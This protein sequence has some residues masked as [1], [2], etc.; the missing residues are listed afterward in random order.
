MNWFIKRISR[1]EAAL[2]RCTED[3]TLEYESGKQKVLDPFSA[4]I[5]ILDD[6]HNGDKPVRVLSNN[7]ASNL[8]ERL[9]EG[10]SGEELYNAIPELKKLEDDPEADPIS[11]SIY[12]TFAAGKAGFNPC[13]TE[14]EPPAYLV[15]SSDDE[16]EDE[17]PEVIAPLFPPLSN[18]SRVQEIHEQKP[19]RTSIHG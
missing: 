18:D 13:V 9:L 10:L 17:P 14:D 5:D 3:I 11:R 2:P 7:S 12:A 8:P 15:D 6:G 4:I 19:K 16:D 1:I